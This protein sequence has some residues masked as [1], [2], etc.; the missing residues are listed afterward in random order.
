[1]YHEPHNSDQ[2]L[3]LQERMEIVDAAMRAAGIPCRLRPPPA[4]QNFK[5]RHLRQLLK[6]EA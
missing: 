5:P 2:G 4:A 3:S 1:M 6:E